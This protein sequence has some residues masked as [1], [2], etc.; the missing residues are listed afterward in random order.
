[1]KFCKAEPPSSSPDLF[2]DG[3]V[4]PQSCAHRHLGVM[5]DSRLSY[6]AHIDGVTSRFRQRVVLLSYMAKYLLPDIVDKLYKGCVRPVVEY[7]SPLWHSRL[8]AH[9]SLTLER[10]QVCVALQ[11]LARLGVNLPDGYRTS[12]SDLLERVRWPSLTWR[13]HIDSMRLFHHLYYCLPTKLLDFDFVLSNSARR[14]G[15]ILLPAGTS[16]VRSTVLYTAARCWNALPPDIRYIKHPKQFLNDLKLHVEASCYNTS[17][18]LHT[19]Y[20]IPTVITTS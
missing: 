11:L 7:S 8:T 18:F 14:Q 3:V 6:S 20:I 19:Q 1:M 4:V 13:R 5:L 12:K 17:G 9:Q 2:V 10:L 15:S 16:Y